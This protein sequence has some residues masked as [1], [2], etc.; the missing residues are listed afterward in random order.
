MEVWATDGFVLTGPITTAL[1]LTVTERDLAPG[2]WSLTMPIVD[3]NS[4]AWE[5]LGF[6]YPGIEVW[7]PATGWRFSGFLTA[8]EESYDPE[9]GDTIT[10]TGTDLMTWLQDRL[11]MPDVTDPANIWDTNVYSGDVQLSTDL[12]GMVQEN[13]AVDHF[14]I[15]YV[16]R[17]IPNIVIGADPHVGPVRNRHVIG[18]PLLEVIHDSCVGTNITARLRLV[19]AAD[20]TPSSLFEVFARPFSPIVLDAQRATL[21]QVRV[22]T[23]AYTATRVFVMGGEFNATTGER[24]MSIPVPPTGTW[25]ERYVEQLN[26]RPSISNQDALNTEAVSILT[27]QAKPITAQINDAP[28]EGYGATINIGWHVHVD[29]GRPGFVVRQTLPVAASKLTFTPNDGWR[30]TIDLG[31]R[32]VYGPEAIYENLARIARRLRIHEGQIGRV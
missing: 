23:E 29:V 20:G 22:K 5:M 6:D 26:S 7:D 12:I 8:V 27:Q 25:R 15:H 24:I 32:I 9:H 28:A 13:A 21:G 30:R 31:T 14:G 19:R 1:A 18:Q 16:D 17:K 3:G 2:G 10:L 4:Q 11:D